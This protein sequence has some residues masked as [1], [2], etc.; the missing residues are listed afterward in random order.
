MGAAGPD[1]LRKLFAHDVTII[2][3]PRQITS[4]IMRGD[5]AVIIGAETDVITKCRSSGG[6]RN[7]QTLNVGADILLPRGLAVF[8][9]APHKDATKIWVNWLLSKEGQEAYVEAWSAED[10][11]VAISQRK[12]VAPHPKL[13]ANI[14]DFRQVKKL[15]LSGMGVQDE[16]YTRTVMRVYGEYKNRNR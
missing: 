6:C 4:A 8:K 15:M 16:N 3:N 7:V 2:D 10:P 11:D 14:P 1:F 13:A 5:K 9:N 12:D